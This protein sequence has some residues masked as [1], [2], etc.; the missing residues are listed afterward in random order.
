MEVESLRE[1]KPR[2]ENQVPSYWVS[3][4]FD[5]PEDSLCTCPESSS[6][7]IVV[8]QQNFPTHAISAGW[9]DFSVVSDH[10]DCVEGV[11]REVL[12]LILKSPVVVQGVTWSTLMKLTAQEEPAKACT[13]CFG[14][15]EQHH[16]AEVAELGPLYRLRRSRSWGSALLGLSGGVLLWRRLMNN[17][18]WGRRSTENGCGVWHPALTAPRVAS[19]PFLDVPAACFFNA[20]LSFFLDGPLILST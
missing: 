19:L 4:H 2:G 15:V 8:L 20:S 6:E 7:D 5:W 14:M 10:G 18:R 12:V 17:G 11:E 16:L 9:T 13:A 3:L 1:P